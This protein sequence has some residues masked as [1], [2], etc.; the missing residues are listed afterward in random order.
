MVDNYG[1]FTLVP[2]MA[3]SKTDQGCSINF[4]DPK[5]I[6]EVSLVV[7]HSFSKDTLI[8]ALRSE[9]LEKIPND[10]IKKK[11]FMKINWR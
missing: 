7:H 3:I 11:N 9:I 5:P 10:F 8:E 6:R 2:E 1:G 4:T